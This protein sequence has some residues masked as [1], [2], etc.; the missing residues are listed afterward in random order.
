MTYPDGHSENISESFKTIDEAVAYGSSMLG[1]IMYTE[2]YHAHDE[3][4]PEL[5]HPYFSVI[6]TDNGKRKI[7]YNSKIMD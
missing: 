6:E 2:Q 3:F 7:V 5:I 4:G 1:Q